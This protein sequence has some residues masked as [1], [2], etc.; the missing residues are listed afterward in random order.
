MDKYRVVIKPVYRKK[1]TGIMCFLADSAYTDEDIESG[2]NRTKALCW[3][4][5]KDDIAKLVN[6]Y[7]NINVIIT[8]QLLKWKLESQAVLDEL[9]KV[10]PKEQ[11][12]TMVATVENFIKNTI[13]NLYD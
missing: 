10:V 2:K 4:G 7:Q 12:N 5:Y 6:Q 1:F 3:V 11:F 13:A 9:E 8:A